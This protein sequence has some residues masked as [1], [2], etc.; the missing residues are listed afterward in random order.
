MAFCNNFLCILWVFM[1]GIFNYSHILPT[2]SKANK[3]SKDK[4]LS[5]TASKGTNTAH[6]PKR[7]KRLP[8]I[9]Q[10]SSKIMYDQQKFPRAHNW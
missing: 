3:H 2:K 10:K 9:D 8:Q 4:D 6:D 7:E 1:S 5:K